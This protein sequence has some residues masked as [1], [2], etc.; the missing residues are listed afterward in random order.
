MIKKNARVISNEK[1]ENIKNCMK[2]LHYA[3]IEIYCALRRNFWNG[4]LAIESYQGHLAR[5]RHDF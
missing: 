5:L 1:F 2:S 4:I 3:P